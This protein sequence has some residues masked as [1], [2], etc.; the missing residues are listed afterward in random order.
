MGIRDMANAARGYL[1][2]VDWVGIRDQTG[3][4]PEEA[5]YDIAYLDELVGVFERAEAVRA[6]L[7]LSWDV[8]TAGS[9]AAWS[10]AERGLL[11]VEGAFMH[12]LN[13]NQP[14]M[15]TQVEYDVELWRAFVSK[16]YL[17]ALQCAV[18]HRN[19]VL[20]VGGVDPA[21]IGPSAD[22]VASSFEAILGLW[23]LGVLDPLRRRNPRQAPLAGLG[24]ITVVSAVLIGSVLAVAI[25]AA[26]MVLSERTQ[27]TMALADDICAAALA[28]TN[29]ERRAALLEACGQLRE[30][31]IAAMAKQPG[32]V[33]LE[34]TLIVLSIGALIY[35]AVLLVP[36]FKRALSRAK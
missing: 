15:A 23:E 7:D 28:E 36:H 3:L 32:E 4:A 10:M 22:A 5:V 27:S 20:Q 11:S 29:P 2:G 13:A 8:P 26:A 6:Q 14:W 34:K 25:I 30:Q 19:L 21:T 31:I 33:A 1:R 18:I 17:D 9:G 12:A 35:G 16:L 24:E